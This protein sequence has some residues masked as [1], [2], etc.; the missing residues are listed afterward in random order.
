MQK[1]RI[2][3]KSVYILQSIYVIIPQLHSIT[4]INKKQ[5]LYSNYHYLV[6]LHPHLSSWQEM[7]ETLGWPIELFSSPPPGHHVRN[8]HGQ[9]WPLQVGIVE[10]PPGC[11]IIQAC[12][13]NMPK[14][15]WQIPFRHDFRHAAETCG[16]IHRYWLHLVT[17]FTFEWWSSSHFSAIKSSV[18]TLICTGPECFF[19]A[20]N[21]KKIEN[22]TQD[23][24]WHATCR[25]LVPSAKQG[26][27]CSHPH[28]F[29]L[30][31][32]RSKCPYL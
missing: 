18:M 22:I 11:K 12:G 15:R 20:S 32:A 3:F 28:N 7:L 30:A 31:H 16:K 8:A 25:Q 26:S 17:P 14:P 13:E 10:P 21:L 5:L 19:W 29:W 1:R 23:W 4:T 2:M 27:P 24:L 6:T 9:R